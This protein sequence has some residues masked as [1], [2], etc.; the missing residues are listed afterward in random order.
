M[1]SYA[2][3]VKFITEGEANQAYQSVKSKIKESFHHGLKRAVS[4]KSLKVLSFDDHY[5]L[6][7]ALPR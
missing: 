6:L 5:A 7:E 3:I 4:K 1:T 2:K